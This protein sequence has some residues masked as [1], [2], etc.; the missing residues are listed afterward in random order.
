M[1]K[2]TLIQAI[3]DALKTA[4]RRDSSVLVMGEDVGVNGGVFRAT[5]GIH[6]EFGPDRAIDTP[7]AESGF[8]GAAFGMA[9]YGLKPVVEIQFDGFLAPAQE[10]LVNHI[11]RI[12]HR[13]RGRFTCPLVLRIP[14]FGGIKALEHHSE[15][16]ENWYVNNPGLKIVVPSNPYDA[17]GLLLAAIE[18]PDPVMFFEPKRLYRAFRAEVPEEYYTVP[19]GRAAIVREGQDMT[20]LT[21]GVHVHTALEAAEKAAAERNWQAEVVDLRS[22][23]P[24]DLDTIIGS[25]RKTGRVVIVT[26]APR[27]GGFH[28]ELI[29][30]INDHALEYL[31]A[32]VARVT[33]FDV[34]M[35]YLLSEDLYIPDAGRV[36]D[37]MTTVRG[38]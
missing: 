5:D 17:K 13:S 35:P 3:N 2:M 12:R 31:E 38:F 23:N 16:I 34:P 36:V 30:Q 15:S 27:S 19:I 32:P 37:A 29:A 1:A 7:L 8:V 25:V 10:H 24:L 4:M 33:G 20:I 26:E 6:T 14:A 22:L 21:Y 9:V 11:A 18:D 28:S